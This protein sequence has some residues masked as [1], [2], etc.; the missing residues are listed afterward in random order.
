MNKIKI[1]KILIILQYPQVMFQGFDYGVFDDSF[2]KD[3]RSSRRGW[4]EK[5]AAAMRREETAV[6]MFE[7]ARLKM[8]ARD[9]LSVGSRETV[10]LLKPSCHLTEACWKSFR[11][12]V[13]SVEGWSTKRRVATEEE[14]K[15][16]G[17]TRK[18]R[19][20]FVDVIYLPSQ[21]KQKPKENTLENY[22]QY[23]GED[24]KC[25]MNKRQLEDE[26][27][28]GPSLYPSGPSLYPSGPSL[29]PMYPLSSSPN[30]RLKYF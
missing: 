2:G 11:G 9:D 20:Y 10:Q 28:A 30:K 27:E 3:L 17:E 8:E 24:I 4:A 5:S 15:K 14:K 7:T 19:V 25:D 13:C 29:Y 1:I 26:S 6:K 16:H 18:G 21:N 22:I 12:H 23:P